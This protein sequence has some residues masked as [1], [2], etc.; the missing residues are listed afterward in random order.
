M[1][2]ALLAIFD[3]V[4]YLAKAGHDHIAQSDGS[5]VCRFVDEY[6]GTLMI[7]LSIL[8]GAEWIAVALLVTDK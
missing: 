1:K 4:I 5:L 2:T 6:F 3:S 8:I 7:S